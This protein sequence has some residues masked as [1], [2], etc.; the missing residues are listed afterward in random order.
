MYQPRFA[1]RSSTKS[2]GPHMRV[3]TSVSNGSQICPFPRRFEMKRSGRRWISSSKRPDDGTSAV[4][5]QGTADSACRA[6][7]RNSPRSGAGQGLPRSTHG[8]GGCLRRERERSVNGPSRSFRTK[9]AVAPPR[10]HATS[11]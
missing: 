3:N 6:S 8:R 4:T 5:T 2:P 9:Q 1:P 7:C 10:P 11:L